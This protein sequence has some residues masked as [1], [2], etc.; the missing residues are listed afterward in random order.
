MK[1]EITETYQTTKYYCDICGESTHKSCHVCNKDICSNHRIADDRSMGDYA[2]Y[3][4]Q[5]CWD[6]GKPYREK[7]LELQ[8]KKEAEVDELEK[9]WY[10]LCKMHYKSKENSKE[11]QKK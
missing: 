2:D 9:Q 3:Y 5:V 7:Q 1:K 11:K 6:I 10:Q 8:L 4:C